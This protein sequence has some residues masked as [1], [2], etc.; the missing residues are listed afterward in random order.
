[1]GEPVV[2]GDENPESM[3]VYLVDNADETHGGYRFPEYYDAYYYYTDENF[4]GFHE[5]F[6]DDAPSAVPLI[7]TV[8]KSHGVLVGLQLWDN[9]SGRWIYWSNSRNV[10]DSSLT[11]PE[12]D[13][14]QNFNIASSED[15]TYWILTARLGVR[16]FAGYNTSN[17]PETAYYV[18]SHLRLVFTK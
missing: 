4:E 12:G 10:L 16:P 9:L 2:R 1:M 6:G 8:P 7:I 18:S 15:G 11:A 5:V 14:D 17:G 13:I 3:Y